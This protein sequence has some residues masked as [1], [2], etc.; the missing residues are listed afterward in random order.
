MGGGGN[1]GSSWTDRFRRLNNDE[2]F[3]FNVIGGFE[4]SPSFEDDLVAVLA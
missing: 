1:G 4:A 2:D 3:L